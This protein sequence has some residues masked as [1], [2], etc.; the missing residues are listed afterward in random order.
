MGQSGRNVELR[1]NSEQRLM[2]GTAVVASRTVL[3][4]FLTPFCCASGSMK[5]QQPGEGGVEGGGIKHEVQRAQKR[6]ENE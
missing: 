2:A 4:S 5:R 3:P 6:D 1:S